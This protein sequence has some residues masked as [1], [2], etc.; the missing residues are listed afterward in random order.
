MKE[1]YDAIV[2]GAGIA[3]V[4]L[5]AMLASHMKVLVLEAESHPAYHATGR[6]AAYFAP[7]Y[8]N[9]VIRDITAE[10]ESFFRSPPDGFTAV[11][12]IFPRSELFVATAEQ[13]DVVHKLK[14]NVPTLTLLTGEELKARVPI[15]K[16]DKLVIGTC[17]DS[18]GDLD[19][20]AILQGFLRQARRAGSKLETDRKVERLGYTNGIWTVET[21]KETFI[22]PLVINAAGAWADEIAKLAGLEGLGLRPLRRTAL[23][24]DAPHGCDI[25]DWPLVVDANER[26]YFKPE[27]GQLMLSPGD[28]TPS[29]PCDAF[30]EEMDIALA[31]DR[32]QQVAD[33]EVNK[34][35]HSWA[36]LRTFAPDRSFVV[37]FDPR[38]TG[39]F[40]FAGQGGY[41]VQSS[42]GLADLAAYLI[43]DSA[44][45]VNIKKLSV[46]IDAIAPDRLINS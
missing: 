1:A 44:S 37:G 14:S 45:F 33:L 2:I 15:L 13:Q 4:S 42:P 28:E 29:A 39:F 24:I 9:Q 23:L 43:T 40:W 3:G 19:V 16:P 10:S 30:A 46:H 32:V 31:I 36:G 7:S 17:N 26:Y 41:G 38:T 12:L 5:S 20:D 8:G 21:G 27:A 11:S 25:T 22:A 34:V 35:N 18:G 6:S